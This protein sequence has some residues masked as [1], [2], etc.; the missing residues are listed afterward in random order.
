MRFLIYL[1]FAAACT[2]A[3]RANAAGEPA[4]AQHST[5][6]A[7][8]P[9]FTSTKPTDTLTRI[10]ATRI[11]LNDSGVQIFKCQEMQLNDKLNMVVKK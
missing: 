11:L 7:P 3:L 2:L 10:Q 9:L 4:K 5:Q 1:S 6:K 8:E